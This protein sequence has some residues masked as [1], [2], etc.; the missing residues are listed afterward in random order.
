MIDDR[1]PGDEWFGD[2]LDF[3]IA[4]GV[5]D[6]EL[7]PALRDYFAERS[8]SCIEI[9]RTELNRS[10]ERFRLSKSDAESLFTGLVLNGIASQKGS[11][12][13]SN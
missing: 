1:I 9:N 3:T 4:R 6:S 8:E 2:D 11:V 10:I 13:R 7:L 12:R 5:S